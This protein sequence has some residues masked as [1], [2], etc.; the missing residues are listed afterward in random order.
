M[1]SDHGGLFL[2]LF[3]GRP[4]QPHTG[5]CVGRLLDRLVFLDMDCAVPPRG[6]RRS[7]CASGVR[8]NSQDILTKSF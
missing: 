4:P 7:C 5:Q 6:F 2:D 3:T 1:H 8:R